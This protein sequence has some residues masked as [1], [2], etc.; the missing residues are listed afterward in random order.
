MKEIKLY[1]C[2]V[3]HTEYND[4]LKANSC[5]KS[6][7]KSIKIAGS[8]YVSKSQNETGYPVA[9]EI[10]MEDGRVVTYKR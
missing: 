6:H 1:V 8:R 3:C 4:K 5:E 9:V 2:E 10:V 7:K